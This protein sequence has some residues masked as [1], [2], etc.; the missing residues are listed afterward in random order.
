MLAVGDR[1]G[2]YRLIGS[3]PG[4]G[5]RAVSDAGR[6]VRVEV[7]AATDMLRVISLV[8][9]LD[10]P[11]IG[12]VVDRGVLTDHRLWLA[13]EIADGVALSEIMSR[14]VLAVAEVVDMIRDVA[15]VL[16]HLHERGLTHDALQPH[17]ITIRTGARSFPIQLGGWSEL[18]A[19]DGRGDIHALG[20]LAYRALTGKFPGLHVPE[21]IPGV[22]GAISSLI[23][24]MLAADPEDRPDAA[25]I[26]LEIAGLSGDRSLAGPRFARPRWTPAPEELQAIA[27]AITL[28]RKR[29]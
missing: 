13:T 28:P 21:L 15:S 29:V 10:H 6:R 1:V 9:S 27:E 20:V 12:R 26:A 18:R 5:F 14:R 25:T 3:H 8:S 19:G 11:G 4:G 23:V 7:A 22:P 17:A 24:R 2:A 16:R